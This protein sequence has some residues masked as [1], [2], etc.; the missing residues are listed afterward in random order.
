MAKVFPLQMPAPQLTRLLEPFGNFSPMGVLWYS[1]GS[2][3]AYERFVGAVE[4]SA[5]LLL[6]IPQ[7]HLLGALLALTASVEIFVLNMTY[8]VP[9]KLFSFHLVLMSSVL[10]A[11]HAPRLVRALTMRGPA[12][13]SWP[14][15]PRCVSVSTSQPRPP[16]SRRHSGPRADQARR[17]R[18]STASGTSSGCVSTASSDCRS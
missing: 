16:T 7:T 14:R 11:P 17:S 13:A 10:I 6:F 8:D 4:L 2:S 15:R 9:V 5:G 18:R 3:F 1:I 12:Y